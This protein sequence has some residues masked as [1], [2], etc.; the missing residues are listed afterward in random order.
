LGWRGKGG[1][2]WRLKQE[3]SSSA[4]GRDGEEDLS[5]LGLLLL[6]GGA[7]EAGA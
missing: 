1:G 2:K 4:A 7:R 3:R 5:I 6:A